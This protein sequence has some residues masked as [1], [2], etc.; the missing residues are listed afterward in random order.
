MVPNRDFLARKSFCVLIT[1]GEG[2]WGLNTGGGGN[3]RPEGGEPCEASRVLPDGTDPPGIFR[4][5]KKSNMEVG[6]T[7]GG[8]RGEGGNMRQE[9][10]V[11][12][13]GFV[14]MTDLMLGV[15]LVARSQWEV[16]CNSCFGG[17]GTCEGDRLGRPSFMWSESARS[18]VFRREGS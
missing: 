15:D 16:E 17:K 7:E 4:P 6:R 18:G 5:G 12:E 14:M 9:E 3:L 1:G 13:E 10:S 11:E 8:K 2:I